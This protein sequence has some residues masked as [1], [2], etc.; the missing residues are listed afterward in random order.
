MTRFGEAERDT[1][2]GRLR[3]EIKTVNHRYFS[4][5]LRLSAAVER[6]EPQVRE[7][8]RGLLP[9]GHVNCSIRLQNGA[10]VGEAPPLVLD[11]AKSISPW[12]ADSVR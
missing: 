3:C 5:N 12:S 7:W 6:F 1:P 10:A 2:A 11:E 8:L 4:V 9:R